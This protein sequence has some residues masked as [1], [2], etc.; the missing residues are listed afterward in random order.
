MSPYWF[1]H[2]V[3]LIV[4]DKLKMKGE[5]LSRGQIQIQSEGAEC[6]YKQ[7]ELRT[8]EDFPA[9]IKAQMRL[10]EEG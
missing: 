3:V 10:R 8:I 1:P 7:M 5:P 2:D 4:L 9:E 6:E